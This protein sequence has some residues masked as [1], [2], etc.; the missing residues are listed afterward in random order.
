MGRDSGATMQFIEPRGDVEVLTVRGNDKAVESAIGMVKA[1]LLGAEMAAKRS[2]LVHTHVME[3]LPDHRGVLVGRAGATIK[4]LQSETGVA[5]E[6]TSSKSKPQLTLSGEAQHVKAAV[7]VVNRLLGTESASFWPPASGT[8]WDTSTPWQEWSGWSCGRENDERSLLLVPSESVPILLGASGTRM[9]KF[10][11]GSAAT[12]IDYDRE[13]EGAP[14]EL[15]TL[16]LFGPSS[17][18]L[19]SSG[20]FFLR[21]GLRE[22]AG[23]SGPGFRPWDV[24]V[25]GKWEQ[26]S[27]WVRDVEPQRTS[28]AL[29]EEQLLQV[30]G[31][32]GDGLKLASREFCVKF[33]FQDDVAS[34]NARQVKL[35]ISGADREVEL[36][37]SRLQAWID[38]LSP[39]VVEDINVP[40]QL[41]GRIIGQ[42]HRNISKLRHEAG[43]AMDFEPQHSDGDH[44]VLR[45]AGR[46]PRV[47]VGIQM[48]Q[49]CV[50]DMMGSPDDFCETIAVPAEL[51]GRVVGKGGATINRIATETGTRLKFAQNE[52][53]E[54]STLQVTGT[55]DGVQVAIERVGVIV[56]AQVGG[57]TKRTLKIPCDTLAAIQGEGAAAI[58]KIAA[59][60]ETCLR[61]LPRS[62]DATSAEVEIVG[63]GPN[64]E[65]AT[66][67]LRAVAFPRREDSTPTHTEENI[68]IQEIENRIV[69]IYQR[70]NPEKVAT[71]SRLMT[72]YKGKEASL[73]ATVARKYNE[74]ASIPVKS[75]ATAT[76][77]E[78][79]TERVASRSRSRRRE[80]SNSSSSSSS[81][82]SSRAPR[83][84][85][86]KHV[87]ETLTVRVLAAPEPEI[88][89]PS[90]LDG[91]LVMSP[92]G[93]AKIVGSKVY[94]MTSLT[95]LALLGGGS[96]Y[97]ASAQAQLLADAASRLVGGKLQ[98]PDGQLGVS[99]AIAAIGTRLFVT[100]DC[101]EPV[102]VA[103]EDATQLKRSDVYYVVEFRSTPAMSRRAAVR[104]DFRVQDTM[105]RVGDVVHVDGDLATVVKAVKSWKST[106]LRPPSELV[107]KQ[108][109]SEEASAWN[110][111]SIV[112]S[113]AVQLGNSLL[114][115]GKVL[116]AEL[117]FDLSVLRLYLRSG[118][119]T[120]E[121]VSMKAALEGV[122]ECFIELLR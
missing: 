56:G 63:E 61:I 58:S 19:S 43:V 1:C 91:Q 103:W 115:G 80:R 102:N 108:A 99:R 9:T 26:S 65:E 25:D 68:D 53:G 15:V 34:G 44:R 45:I 6:L 27:V 55:K 4:R 57:R 35:D 13:L 7:A 40:V 76:E 29:S 51:I 28:L 37:S 98:T 72:K 85:A 109:S 87:T 31:A 73:F 86:E 92:A 50:K 5:F 48:I 46:A 82:A 49:K 8:P 42:H 21:E 39:Q 121:L 32:E 96:L 71:V 11:R 111:L 24:E 23:V 30:M 60:T 33:N 70:K 84:R 122:F 66:T 118:C 79:T 94:E 101:G 78:V 59:L 52:S 110:S 106:K 62:C 83:A 18:D 3:I 105:H 120:P 22:A 54:E 69:D 41:V 16:K 14:G 81:A 67:Q 104:H 89:E 112:E 74:P 38:S 77:E 116:A 36:C 20:V 64:V 97:C 100:V 113:R 12:G 93:P 119:D 10:L 114:K 47:Q 88:V 75:R 107:G 2:A 17:A 90:P 117:R 95:K